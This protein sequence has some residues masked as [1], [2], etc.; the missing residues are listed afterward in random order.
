MESSVV[1]IDQITSLNPGQYIEVDGIVHVQA[2]RIDDVQFHFICP[3]CW[4][5][6]KRN[7]KPSRTAKRVEHHHISSGDLTIRVEQR[8]AQC[9]SNKNPNHRS[10]K[11]WITQK[12]RGVGTRRRFYLQSNQ[13]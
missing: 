12:T 2:N 9:E 1:V 13:N 4:T 3:F 6:Y 8:G 11:I 10:F 7:G 5:R